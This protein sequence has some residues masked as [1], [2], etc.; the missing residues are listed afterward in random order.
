MPIIDTSCLI[1]LIKIN[2]LYLLKSLFSKVYIIEE[3]LAEMESGVEGITEL[4]EQLNKWIFIEKQGNR[5]AILKLSKEESIEYT[6]AS[7]ILLAKQKKNILVS[8]DSTLIRVAKIKGIKCWWLTTCILEALKRKIIRKKEAKEILLS[9]I[10]NGM[11]LDNKVYAILLNEID[12][13]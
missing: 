8:N 3:V 2:K 1:Y 12:K 10:K 9:L 13:L 5:R 6:D 11:Y 7:L 4:K